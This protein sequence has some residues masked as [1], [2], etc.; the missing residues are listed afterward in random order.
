MRLLAIL[1][2]VAAGFAQA[3]A[4]DA[5]DDRGAGSSGVGDGGASDGT[6]AEIEAAER[7]V[8]L[9]GEVRLRLRYTD[10][11][12][13]G[14]LV[15]TYGELLSRGV[16][17]KHRFTLEASYPATSEI[18]VGGL[19]RISNEGAEALAAGPEYFSSEVGSAFAAYE[20]PALRSRLG[21]Y[22]ISYTPLTLARWDTEDDPGAG[23][24][25]SCGCGASDAGG[26][27]L[28]ETLEELGPDLTFEGAR[29]AV[30]PG[31]TLEV[32]GFFARPRVAAEDY[33]LLTFGGRANLTRYSARTASFYDLSVAAM[34]TEE[35][36][37]SLEGTAVDPGVP[38]RNTVYGLA[39]NV[40]LLKA[41][42]L[43]SL[44]LGGE[45]TLTRSSGG[46]KREGKGGIVSLSASTASA[47]KAEI[48]YIYLSPNWDSHFRALSY[49]PNRR[50]ARAR[51]EIALANVVVTAF[52]KH[53]ETID[54]G[55]S[56][57][58]SQT[59][60][61]ARCHVGAGRA[62][63]LGLG[64]I[65]AASGPRK[66]GLT[67]DLEARRLSLIGDLTY[68]FAEDSFVTLEERCVWNSVD[69]GASAGRDYRSSMLSLYVRAAIW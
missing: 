7:A 32:E 47:V 42:P 61:S 10:S 44:A 28:G 14:D 23:G 67:L 50:G 62:L 33:Q 2:V 34:R 36:E 35:E 41:A 55:A 22:S 6:E 5:G 58:T 54:A 20:T 65:F 52:A 30:S 17:L 12:D 24:A 11:P 68:E 1:I 25:S 63:G 45:W 16:S 38:S 8:D 31:K 13:T 46:A 39:W 3:W 4:A 21:Y 19:V 27:I 69:Q 40:P 56:A 48:A 60:L 37:N 18:T 51:L 43:K 15:G 9:T 64:T 29:V 57:D 66:G 26:A 49:D 53:L 59:T